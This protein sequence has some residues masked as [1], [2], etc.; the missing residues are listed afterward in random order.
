MGVIT[1][2]HLD[3]GELSDEELVYWRP[4]VKESLSADYIARIDALH[5]SREYANTDEGWAQLKKRAWHE[6]ISTNKVCKI[7]SSISAER[8]AERM[9]ADGTLSTVELTKPVTAADVEN[10][11]RASNDAGELVHP[12][13]SPVLEGHLEQLADLIND[14][15]Q[16]AEALRPFEKTYEM[17]KSIKDLFSRLRTRWE[18]NAS[19]PRG[20]DMRSAFAPSSAQLAGFGAA[21]L[22]DPHDQSA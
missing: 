8:R 20:A 14:P 21:N 6:T 18:G 1:N 3:D 7:I 2:E 13:G 17:A 10:I 19:A 9:L 15:Q 4:R 11:L 12:D 22:R 5:A 16:R